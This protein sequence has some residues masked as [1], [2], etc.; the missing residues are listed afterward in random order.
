MTGP[1]TESEGERLPVASQTRAFS[2]PRPFLHP[3]CRLYMSVATPAPRLSA[4]GITD[5]PKDV[6]QKPAGRVELAKS[7]APFS[8]DILAPIVDSTG[9][10][11]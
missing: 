10:T 3:S 4:I 7:A 5:K 8:R 11:V 2:V 6:L 9:S 1:R